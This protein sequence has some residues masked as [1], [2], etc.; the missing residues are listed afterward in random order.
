MNDLVKSCID[1][2]K[3]RLTIFSE[4]TITD[5]IKEELVRHYRL[6]EDYIRENPLFLSAYEP[7]PVKKNAP[8]IA[9]DMA[10]AAVKAD[11]GP[12]A[13]VAGAFSDIM[14]ELILNKGSEEAIV[15]NGGDIFIKTTRERRVKI[16]AGPSKL[17]EKIGFKVAPNETPLGICTS[18]DSVGHSISLG[19]SDAVAA[20]ASTA[21]LADAAATAIGNE[22][23]GENPIKKG[24]KKAKKIDG[25]LGAVIIKDM[26]A[27]FWGRLPEII[28]I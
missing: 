3:T 16:H 13:A 9:R 10:E 27:G 21:C 2:K 11:V 17:S 4:N 8:R 23:G 1:Y 15:I 24:I 12:M 26:D 22:T 28:K 7:L 19:R 18:S 14:G 20:V 6:L 5:E 25:L